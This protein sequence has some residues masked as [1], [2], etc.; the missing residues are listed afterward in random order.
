MLFLISKELFKVSVKTSVVYVLENK[1]TVPGRL[2][3]AIKSPLK[4]RKHPAG[5]Q[6]SKFAWKPYTQKEEKIQCYCNWQIMPPATT[7]VSTTTTVS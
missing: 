2:A 1:M 4:E 6:R 5:S 3:G 7:S